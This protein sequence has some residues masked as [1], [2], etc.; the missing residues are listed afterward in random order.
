MADCYIAK[1]AEAQTDRER[2]GN[3]YNERQKIELVVLWRFHRPWMG[4][5]IPCR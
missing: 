1:R 2:L 3:R 4:V 5:A